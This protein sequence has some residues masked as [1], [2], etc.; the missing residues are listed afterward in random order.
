MH[1]WGTSK[2]TICSLNVISNQQAER[3]GQQQ[4]GE[5]KPHYINKLQTTGQRKTLKQVKPNTT[6]IQ[7]E[8][9]TV[10]VSRL[11]K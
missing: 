10:C 8:C 11:L 5:A 6:Q 7:R 9:R 2:A 4:V 1:K 3:T